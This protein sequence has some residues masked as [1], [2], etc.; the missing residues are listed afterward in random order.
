VTKPIEIKKRSTRGAGS[1]F[2]KVP[3]SNRW[4][5]SYYIPHYDPASGK[6]RSKRVKEYCGLP[7]KTAQQLLND[8]VGK[9]ARGEQV[10][11]GKPK[12]VGEL[13]HSLHL[14]ASNNKTP[15]SR[16]VKGYGWR[17]AHLEPT[18]GHLRAAHVTYEH[19]EAYKAQRRA[20]GAAPATC[21]REL[22]TL[23]KIF[24]HAKKTRLIAGDVPVIE[25]FSEKDNVRKGF[26][27]DH[28]FERLAAEAAKD[29]LFMRCLIEVFFTYG[30]R[31]SEVLNLRVRHVDLAHRTIRLD[32]GTT[33]NGEGREVA[34]TAR[35]LELMREAC[36]EKKP[37]DPVFTREDGSTVKSFSK[38]WRNLCV[39]AGVPGLLIHDFRRS[40]AR[41]LRKA[42]VPES[43][44]MATG[45][46]KTPAM[47]R[48]YAIVSSADPRDA[49]T[50]LEAA[51]RKNG[52]RFSPPEAETAQ[53]DAGKEVTTIQ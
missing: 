33:K 4:H 10:A 51:R 24:H 43:V 14:F 37:D 28:Q 13:Y 23:R 25:M 1:L 30:W 17:W 18:F 53:N 29:G 48:R 9:V 22:A 27:E 42:G 44:I 6:T 31:R 52:P 7:K 16:K 11:A 38:T 32:V 49:M 36:A 12:T 8:R 35:V 5:L 47:F 19:V 20:Q 50:A 46:W 3:G 2:E 39:R 41:Q 15:G 21:N 26:I 45:G 34:M 40:A